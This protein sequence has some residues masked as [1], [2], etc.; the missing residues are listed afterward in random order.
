LLSL[1]SFPR[2]VWF[3]VPM[4]RPARLRFASAVLGAFLLHAI[5]ASAQDVIERPEDIQVPEE[6]PKVDVPVPGQG[7]RTIIPVPEIIVSP[8]EGITGGVLGVLLFANPDKSINGIFAPDIRY[9]GITGVWPT[10]RYF[11]YPDPLQKYSIVAG[12]ATK[13][14]DFFDA[15]Y[16]GEKRLGGLVDLQLNLRRDED[17]FERFYGFGNETKD[18]DETNYTG[19]VHRIVAYAGYN[20]LEWLRGSFQ[21]RFRHVQIGSGE[22]DDVQ[23]LRTSDLNDVEGID[24]ATIVG[25]R[26]GISVDTRDRADIPSEGYFADFAVEVVDDAIGATD[27]FVN[28]GMEAKGFLPLER[29]VPVPKKRFLL[30]LH[31][32]LD[33]MGHGSDAP[34]YERNTVGGMESLRSE[35]RNRFTDKHRFVMQAELRS[36]V[37]RREVFGVKAHIELAPFLDF[38]KVFNDTDEFPISNLHAAGGLGVRAVV[39]PQVVAYVDVGTGG[40]TPAVFT[41]IDYPF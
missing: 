32:N 38:A 11:G 3:E 10:L 31:T 30:A 26:W 1:L 18:G 5:A 23:N 19:T 16:V 6:I 14:G 9:N 8:T 15:D 12:K 41:G 27:S 37:Y 39:V 4:L 25:L 40:D 22:V 36:E 7:K 33:Y 28:Y 34:F 20:A 17:P 13:H 29:F 35:G 2:A 24:G 21:F